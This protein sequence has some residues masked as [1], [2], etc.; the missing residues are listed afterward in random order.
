MNVLSLHKIEGILK[1]RLI[2]VT[3]FPI[4]F[5]LNIGLFVFGWVIFCAR[6]QIELFLTAKHYWFSCTKYQD[7]A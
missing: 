5:I 2:I 3:T 6:N 1:R 4:I 7:K